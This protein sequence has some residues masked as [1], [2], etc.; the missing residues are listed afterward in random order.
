[1]LKILLKKQLTEIFRSYFYDAKKEQGARY[2]LPP[3][4]YHCAVCRC[5]MVGVLGGIFTCLSLSICAS[6][7]SR[8]AWAG[9]TSR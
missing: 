7:G 8:R 4:A 5:C 2:R 6:S 1:M 9:C 3:C